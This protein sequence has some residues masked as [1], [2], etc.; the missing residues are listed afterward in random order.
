MAVGKGAV[1]KWAVS[2][3]AEVASGTTSVSQTLSDSTFIRT[4]ATQTLADSYDIAAAGLSVTST[5]A[6]SYTITGTVAKSLADSYAILGAGVT[7]SP[8]DL[9]AIWD[10]EIETGYTA[11]QMMKI[12]FAAL[13]GKREG[14]GT[15]V[16]Y[17]YDVPTGTIR[18]ITFTPDAHGNGT[19][20]VDGS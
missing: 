20:V 14:I 11:R 18:R 17:Y 10:L 3:A 12:M 4:S 8:E 1:G 7:L 15:P 9:A 5:L 2:H 16:E 6:D 13:A 19:P